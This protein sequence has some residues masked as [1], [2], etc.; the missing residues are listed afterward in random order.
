[1]MIA[2]GITIYQYATIAPI[3]NSM[4]RITAEPPISP[5]LILLPDEEDDEE[6]DVEL[7]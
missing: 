4:P 1:M 5:R 3:A 2:T 7:E 6:D